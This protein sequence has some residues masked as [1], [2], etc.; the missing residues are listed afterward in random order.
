[1]SQE[2]YR[3]VNIVR[4]P[5]WSQHSL[6][7]MLLWMNVSFEERDAWNN[8]SKVS[9]I[10]L[11]RKAKEKQVWFYLK[12]RNALQVFFFSDASSLFSLLNMAM[13]LGNKG[14]GFTWHMPFALL[15]ENLL[16]IHY[17]LSPLHNSV[18]SHFVVDVNVIY[19][20]GL[21]LCPSSTSA[22]Q[23][24]YVP[25]AATKHIPLQAWD[26]CVTC[27]AAKKP[28]HWAIR[29]HCLG[30]TGCREWKTSS[31]YGKDHV[32]DNRGQSSD[33]GTEDREGKDTFVAGDWRKNS[34]R[35][36]Q[37]T[38]L[39]NRNPAW[40]LSA[41]NR[42]LWKPLNHILLLL[43]NL[44]SPHTPASTAAPAAETRFIAPNPANDPQGRNGDLC[45]WCCAVPLLFL[46]LLAPV[47]LKLSLLPVKYP[48]AQKQLGK[49][50][51]S[52][53]TAIREQRTILILCLVRAFL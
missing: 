1:M 32:G 47:T 6:H 51:I 35:L 28:C 14:K 52:L 15:Y 44:F 34:T 21:S 18:F 30:H 10:I 42:E 43:P 53:A 27:S 26:N 4:C 12:E 46:L 24:T 36:S 7:K 8:F 2:Q 3:I 48:T 31:G 11:E 29:R 19:L 37:K 16:R 38:A 25:V 45:T 41:L 49:K 5:C 20:H 9:L 39:E 13:T 22:M 33:L 50:Q 40:S 23:V 17:M